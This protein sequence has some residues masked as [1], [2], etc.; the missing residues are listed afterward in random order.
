MMLKDVP[1]GSRVLIDVKS[2]DY[3][4]AAPANDSCG[5]LVATKLPT[6]F[7]YRGISIGFRIGEKSANQIGRSLN[8]LKTDLKV[9]YINWLNPETICYPAKNRRYLA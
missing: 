7:G 6:P 9:Q 5:W 8:D 1:I 3:A 4:I 2:T